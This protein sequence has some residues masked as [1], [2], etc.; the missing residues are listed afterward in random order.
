M[1]RCCSPLEPDAIT[2]SNT[3]PPLH[4][5]VNTRCVDLLIL[6]NLVNTMCVNLVNALIIH[7][8]DTTSQ[9]LCVFIKLEKNINFQ[10]INLN[11]LVVSTAHE[12]LILFCI[13]F[14]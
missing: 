1:L 12:L 11:V 10:V 9:N 6:V 3:S 2:A 5:Q 7:Y 13:F 14:K 4:Q 8:L